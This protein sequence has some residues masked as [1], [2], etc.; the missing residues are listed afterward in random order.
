MP[1]IH[2]VPVLYSVL[3]SVPVYP[4]VHE[5]SRIANGERIQ[6]WY[7]ECLSLSSQGRNSV[8]TVTSK[9]TDVVGVK[10]LCTS[11]PGLNEGSF[12]KK[13]SWV[14]RKATRL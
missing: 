6:R 11:L 9:D 3:H 2:S 7:F 5:H 1:T 14:N 4:D 10:L 8:L 12:D 13:Y